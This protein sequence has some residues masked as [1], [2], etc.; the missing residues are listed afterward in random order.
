M[1]MISYIWHYLRRLCLEKTALSR[2]V[3]PRTFKMR[4]SIQDVQILLLLDSGSSHSFISEQVTSV[5]G[6][7]RKSSKQSKS[8]QWANSAS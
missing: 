1:W 5:G 8:G 4:G 3:G 2:K 6:D 7:N